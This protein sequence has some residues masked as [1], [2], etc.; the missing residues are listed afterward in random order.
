V[1]S[2]FRDRAGAEPADSRQREP[3]DEPQ[4]ADFVAVEKE[5]SLLLRRA[6]AYHLALAADLRADLNVATYA[7]LLYIFTNEG[8]R[9]ADIAAYFGIHKGAVSRQITHLEQVGLITRTTA[10]DD[11]RAQLLVPTVEGRKQFEEARRK[12][13]SRVRDELSEW[14]PDDV[15]QFARLLSRF[16]AI[17]DG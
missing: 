10:T 13:S 16:N 3:G 12:R 2:V 5:L 17:L 14:D 8:V 7:S 1:P 6:R 11:G 4:A 15:N 9:A